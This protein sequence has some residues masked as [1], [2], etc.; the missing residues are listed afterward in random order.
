VGG[1]A[2]QGLALKLTPEMQE[3]V[4]DAWLQLRNHVDLRQL[5]AALQ[6]GEFEALLAQL[7]EQNE[8]Y[9]DAVAVLRQAVVIVGESAAEELGAFIGENLSFELTNPAAVAEL[10]AAGAE[11]VTNV[12]DETIAALREAL[13]DAYANGRTG[14]QVARDIRDMIGLTRRD[15]GQLG[16]LRE[17]LAAQVEA[18]ELTQAQMDKFLD[19]WVRAKIRYR[20]Q[21]IADHELNRAGNYGQQALWDQVQADGLMPSNARRQ[22]VVAMPCDICAPMAGVQT[23][24]QQPWNTPNGKTVMIPT[25]THVRCKCTFILVFIKV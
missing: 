3:A 16:R 22:W 2:A 10:E 11:M 4:L 21:V 5:E 18:G 1:E 23:G 8:V 25:D 24:L 13:V 15:V 9:E 20:A 17:E 7:V 19:K 12:S 14:Q 6:S